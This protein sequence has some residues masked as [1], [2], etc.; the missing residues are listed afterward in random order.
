MASISSVG[1]GIIGYGYTG[2]QLARA[3]KHVQNAT[4]VAIADV[5]EANRR[6]TSNPAFADYR[7]LLKDSSVDAVCI[8]L[9]H[10]LHEEVAVAAIEAGKDLLVEKPLCISVAAGERV[11]DLAR[12]AEKILMVE[13]TH[14]FLQPLMDA[15]GIISDEAIGE[16]LAI[17]DVVVEDFGLFGAPPSWMFERTIAGGGVGLT[18][19]IHLFDH[20]MWLAGQPLTLESARLMRSQNFGDV[21][22]TASFSLHLENGAPV[23]ILLCTRANGSGLEGMINIYGSKGTL[24]VRPWGGWRLETT[25]RVDERTY[26]RPETPVPE[27]AL[28]GMTGAMK[29]FISAVRE[30]RQ[31][32][33]AP[34]ASLVSQRLIEQAYRN[35]QATASVQDKNRRGFSTVI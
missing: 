30:R 3:L 27:R 4:L 33:P 11:C 9:P 1:V 12:K 14:R 2:Q 16:I 26:F 19:G 10:A 34:Q 29:E 25:E 8:C 24:R 7:D 17:N 6:Q 28:A 31:P 5:N 22:D 13:M 32:D 15:R 23:H 21:E 20:V 35:N 18:S